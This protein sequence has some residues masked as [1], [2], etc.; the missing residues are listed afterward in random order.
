MKLRNAWWGPP[1]KFSTEF[2]DRKVSWLELFYDLVY[3]I[4]IS[5]I[6]HHLA[7]HPD[8]TGLL[9]YTYFFVMIFWGWLNGSLYHDLHGTSGVRTSLMTLWQMMIVAGLVV[10]VNN[11]GENMLFNITIC[12]MIMQ[13]YITYLWWSVGIYDKV[14]RRLNRPWTVIYLSS[15]ALMILTLYLEQ[16]YIRIVFYLTL[17]LNYLPPFVVQN[18]LRRESS[19]FN[20]SSSM[21]ERMGL[22]TI[23]IFGETILGVVTGTSELGKLNWEVWI[24]FGLSIMI[25][26]ALWWI[27]FSLVSDRPCRPGYVNSHKMELLYIPTLMG[28]G[29]TG[30]AFSSLFQGHTHPETENAYLLKVGF[31]VAMCLFLTGI[32]LMLTFLEYPDGYQ[33][34]K[35]SI[36]K[37]LAITIAVL[38]LATCLNI[39]LDLGIYLMIVLGVLVIFILTVQASWLKIEAGIIANTNE[40]HSPT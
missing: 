25:V 27:F 19:D 23:I 3:V 8:V 26:F 28:L 11:S 34:S 33:N 31:G 18:L 16:P 38:L 36:Q 14:H 40:Q 24:N 20:L 5:R 35:R 21:A 4:A 39:V 17:V 32:T 30:V 2:E 9:D 15:L 1:K 13:L 29:V 7:E 6:T 10:T 37:R 22:F 12:V